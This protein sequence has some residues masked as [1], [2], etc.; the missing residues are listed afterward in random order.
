MVENSE[1]IYGMR[2]RDKG[3]KNLN[4]RGK[5]WYF[6]AK[7]NGVWFE[8]SL[9]TDNLR[10]AKERDQILRGLEESGW[11]KK[12]ATFNEVVEASAE[13][14]FPRIKPTSAKRYAASIMNLA[15]IFDGV[16][17]DE[18]DSPMIHDFVDQRWQ[19]E[20]TP[21][22]IRRDL[23]CLSVMWTFAR[24]RGDQG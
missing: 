16:I 15:N 22:T 1:G 18:I 21:S 5:I 14:H 2:K 7:K 19:D 17:W 6:R 9:Q 10:R 3:L 12:K 24:G 8:Q 4:R 23:A 11:V 20:V 13:I